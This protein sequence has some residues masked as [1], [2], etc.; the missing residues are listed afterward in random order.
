MN[1]FPELTEQVKAISVLN[2]QAKQNKKE[3][4]KLIRQVVK[5]YKVKLYEAWRKLTPEQNRLN[6]NSDKEV[7]TLLCMLI[8]H[9][10]GHLHQ[11]RTRVFGCL[12]DLKRKYGVRVIEEGEG[13]AIISWSLAD[14]EKE[15][16]ES[17]YS[18]YLD[19]WSTLIN[20]CKPFVLIVFI[21]LDICF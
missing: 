8:A 1:K 5:E 12:Y 20:K 13:C 18:N 17:S 7:A 14:Q 11:T 19:E 10:R 21:C 2:K 3:Y 15:L 4:E 9:L 16:R 6:T